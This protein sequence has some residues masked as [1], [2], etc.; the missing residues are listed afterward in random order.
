MTVTPEQRTM[1]LGTVQ[2]L[3]RRVSELST[4]LSHVRILHTPGAD[5]LCPL[6]HVPL[7][8]TAVAARDPRPLRRSRW[9]PLPRKEGS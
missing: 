6:C 8:A 4:A 5:G 9:L 2:R 7:C 1:T 3:A